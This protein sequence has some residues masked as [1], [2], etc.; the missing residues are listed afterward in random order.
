MGENKE[1]NKKQV[2]IY[3]CN[4]VYFDGV[5]DVEENDDVVV[6]LS[7]VAR[8]FLIIAF[9]NDKLNNKKQHFVNENSNFDV[10]G[11]RSHQRLLLGQRCTCADQ[12][13]LLIVA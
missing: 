12:R 9:R 11:D 3:K 8:F 5:V 7:V 4:F 2:Y 1:N 10:V 6:L 13:M